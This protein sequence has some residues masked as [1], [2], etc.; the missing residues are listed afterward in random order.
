MLF[1]DLLIIYTYIRLHLVLEVKKDWSYTSTGKPRLW[2]TVVPISDP[3]TN[4]YTISAG[5]GGRAV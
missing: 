1:M 2:W 3:L 5:H 4:S